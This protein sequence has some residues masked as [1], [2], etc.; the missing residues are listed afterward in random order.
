MTRF[1][2]LPQR[3]ELSA[4]AQSSVHPIHGNVRGLSGWIDAVVSDGRVDAGH[5]A[6]AHVELDTDAIK[7]DN[8]LVNKEMQRRLNARR[9]PVIRADVG[10]IREGSDGRFAVRGELTLMGAT[11]EVAGEA[12]ATVDPDGAL[13]VEGELT[14]D[15]RDFGLDP[16]KMLGLR[17][18]PEVAVRL[19]VVAT[20]DE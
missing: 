13:T 18:Y 20:P 6:K 17:V 12:S 7:A 2:I 1:S 16:P 8:M 15:M 3:S 19:R 5:P 11:R 4:A 14:L 10:E 9:Y